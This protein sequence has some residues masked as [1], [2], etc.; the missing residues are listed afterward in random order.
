MLSFDRLI[1]EVIGNGKYQIIL[2]AMVTAQ[3][4]TGAFLN[5]G[6]VF[7][8]KMCVY[9]FLFLNFGAVNLS[10]ADFFLYML[11]TSLVFGQK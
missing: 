8:G 1:D 9:F 7:L 5:T 3:A 11:S 2:I 6:A 4:I 10:K